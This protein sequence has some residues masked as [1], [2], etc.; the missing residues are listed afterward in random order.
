MAPPAE[1]GCA[2]LHS[3]HVR[4]FRCFRSVKVDPLARVN[5][6]VGKNNAGKTCLLEAL[7]VLMDPVPGT[8]GRI[9]ERREEVV[10]DAESKFSAPVARPLLSYSFF[11]RELSNQRS[12]EIRGSG[13]NEVDEPFERYVEASPTTLGLREWYL[14]WNDGHSQSRC[15]LDLH[16]VLPS[17]A[18][19][20]GAVFV[21]SEPMTGKRAANLWGEI[22][23]TSREH[24]VVAA[25]QILEP[26]V[27]RIGAGAQPPQVFLGLEG[28][29][30]RHPL[31]HFGEGMGRLFSLASHLALTSGRTLLVDDI[32]AGLHVSTMEA[33]WTMVLETTANLDVQL[34]ATTHSDDCLRGL[35]AA[36]AS[37]PEHHG[38]IALHRLDRAREETVHYDA[39]QIIQSAEAGI[40]VRG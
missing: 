10:L 26:T 35:A 30:D 9:A 18:S 4:A 38:A 1:P 23:G 15:S 36:L 28:D 24:R 21:G 33:M 17:P 22:S 14:L 19:S 20:R 32:D 29:D 5:V 2:H 34:F 16:D 37:H 11:G 8:L 7:E 3:L 27:Q 39:A 25:L 13:S 31:G 6:I 12:F 40:E